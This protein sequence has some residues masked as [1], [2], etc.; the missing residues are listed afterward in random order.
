MINKRLVATPPKHGL[1][2]GKGRGESS[3]TQVLQKDH[4][5]VYYEKVQVKH[6]LIY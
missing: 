1:N 3:N 5:I 4:H 6:I 2:R